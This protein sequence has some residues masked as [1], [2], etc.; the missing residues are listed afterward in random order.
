MRPPIWIPSPSP[1]SESESPVTIALT[2]RQPEDEV[3]VLA[4]RVRVDAERPRSGA[5]EVPFALARAQPREVLALHA[6][7]AVGIDAELLDPVLPG[8]GGRRVHR[9]AEAAC[10]ALV[11]RRGQD[12]GGRA[13]AQ[14][15][16]NRERVEQQEVVADRDPVRRD[17]LGPPLLLVPVRMGRLP[18]PD[19]GLELPHAAI[20][21]E[22]VHVG[23]LAMDERLERYAEL[24]VRVGA[25]VQPGQEV[26]VHGLVEHAE[27][28][29]A[30]TRQAYRAGASY[31]NVAATATSTSGGR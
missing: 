31:V 22:E 2:R 11:V 14:L 4:A 23:S 30:L 5:V 27:L 9:Q 17:E 24:A 6:A 29:R 16:G 3:V 13:L 18:V 21:R 12:D 25:N 20:L 26:F 10:V 1:K 7:H 28:V 19:T 8:V 15:V